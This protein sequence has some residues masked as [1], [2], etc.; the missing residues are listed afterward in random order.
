MTLLMQSNHKMTLSGHFQPIEPFRCICE[1]LGLLCLFLLGLVHAVLQ[2]RSK[3]FRC[4][5]FFVPANE[6]TFDWD[7]VPASDSAHIYRVEKFGHLGH[8][9]PEFT[10]HLGLHGVVIK[11]MLQEWCPKLA[12][13][14]ILAFISKKIPSI[15]HFNEQSIALCPHT[16]DHISAPSEW[17]LICIPLCRLRWTP[18]IL[19]H[20][21]VLVHLSRWRTQ[22][23]FFDKMTVWVGTYNDNEAS[24]VQKV[25]Q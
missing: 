16:S 20:C 2:S 22:L 11:L 15:N 17:S 12:R 25:S 21:R 19:C 1:L 10:R 4:V 14:C 23:T 9:D 7:G 13:R 5:Y 6:L 18:V 24:L 3:I 8:C